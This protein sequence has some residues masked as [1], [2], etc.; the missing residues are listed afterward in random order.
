MPISEAQPDEVGST[1]I[2]EEEAPKS[3]RAFSRVKRELSDE[4]L[5]S[6]GVQ[7]LLL[8]LLAQAEE[9]VSALKSFQAKYHES[10]KRNGALEEKLKKHTALEIASIAMLAVGGG[11][12]G[13]APKMWSQ[14]PAGWVLLIT[15]G[16]LV[17]GGIATKVV[18]R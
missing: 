11:I 14:Q 4:D 10:D 15:G 6:P 2:T 3:H 9:E 8:E 13:L 7:K 16:V 1:P 5:N 18:R 17:I 12:M